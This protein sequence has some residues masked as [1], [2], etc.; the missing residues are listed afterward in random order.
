[1][2]GAGTIRATLEAVTSPQDPPVTP[3]AVTDADRARFRKLINEPTNA[4]PY[5]DAQI[6]ALMQAT[7]CVTPLVD[8]ITRL[9][10][11]DARLLGMVD[12]HLDLYGAAALVWEDKALAAQAGESGIVVREQTGG[13]SVEYAPGTSG[14]AGLWALARR[15][16]RRSCNPSLTRAKTVTVLPPSTGLGYGPGFG[17]PN[18]TNLDYVTST[19]VPGEALPLSITDPAVVNGP[20]LG[21]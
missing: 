12:V 20:P 4:D 17:G 11:V 10:I 16:R 3:P 15:M 6:N 8:P 5:T 9:P 19:D 1:M 21:S 7:L 14:S 2:S 13:N 18:E